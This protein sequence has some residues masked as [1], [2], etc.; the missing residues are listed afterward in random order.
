M[1]KFSLENILMINQ[2]NPGTFS[3]Q[4]TQ[5]ASATGPT[6]RC[7]RIAHPSSPSEAVPDDAMQGASYLLDVL[8]VLISKF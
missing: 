1:V 8:L 6:A 3:Y 5:R 2:T 4:A 7:E